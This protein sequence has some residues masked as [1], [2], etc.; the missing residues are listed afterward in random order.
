[1]RRFDES[2][3]RPRVAQVDN[4][5]TICFQAPG[6][7]SESLLIE[8]QERGFDVNE[9]I[10]EAL[11]AYLALPKHENRRRHGRIDVDLSA[12]AR[13]VNDE[14]GTRILS[15]K[16]MDLSAGGLK[17]QCECQESE[18]EHLIGVGGQ[19]EII[20]TVPEREYPVCFTCE[21]KHVYGDQSSE[22]GC[23][24]VKSSGDSLDVLKSLLDGP[25]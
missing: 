24:F 23:E 14:V 1:M 10:C 7:M 5:V 2:S 13:P 22:L 6:K 12:V 19:V 11:E 21:V 9:L 3:E 18:I 8:A 25:A 17:L 15:G 16:I 4:T 20:F